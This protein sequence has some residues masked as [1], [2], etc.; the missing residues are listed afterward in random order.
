M[1]NKSMLWASLSLTFAAGVAHAEGKLNIYNWTDYTSP[2]MITKFEKETG[3][4]VT[5]DTYDSNE[6]LLAKMQA[7]A[8]GYDIIVPSHN[9]IP[10]FISEGLVQEVDVKSMPNYQNVADRWRNPE[11]DPEQKYSVPFHWGSA[12]VSYR[13]DLYGKT[14]ESYGDFFEPAEELRGRISV[15]K[16][17]EE[18]VNHAHLYLGQEFCNEDPAQMQ[19]VQDLLL[20]QKPY[21]MAYSSEGMNDRL[22]NGDAILSSHWNGYSYKGRLLAEEVGK[23][24]VYAYPK[25]GI[26]G[27]ADGLMVPKSAENVENAKI[28]MNFIMDPENMGMQSNFAG[29]GGPIKGQE[30]F[31]DE[32]LRNAPEINMP[33][34]A[35]MIFS[36]ACNANAQ[37]LIDRVWTNVLR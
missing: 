14:L 6:T 31:E 29:Y 10:I 30:E 11:W 7:G 18:V 25:E 23:E 8:T 15:F 13:P 1:K 2:E 32:S 26:I 5:L 9:F 27:W 37:S 12:S 34:D 16:T 28:F 36:F 4:E 17:P 24:V 20:A 19:K 3:I 22:I 33:E 21:V 35:K